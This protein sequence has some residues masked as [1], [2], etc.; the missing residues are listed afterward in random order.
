MDRTGRPTGFA[1]DLF[2]AVA[3]R[4]GLQPVYRV[5]PSYV[6]AQAALA[7]GEVEVVPNLGVVEGRAFL[8]TRPVETFEVSAFVRRANR[9][10]TSLVDV[11]GPIAVV[12]ANVGGR[13]VADLTH[14]EPVVFDNVRDALFRLLSGDVDVL[15]YPAPVVWALARR[16]RL[17]QEIVELEPPLLEVKRAIAV[18]SRSESLRD[19]LDESVRGFVGSAEYLVIYRRWHP[20]V[21]GFWTLRRVVL[22]GLG[23]FAVV[24]LGGA[25]ARVAAHRK[26]ERALRARERTFRALAEGLSDCVLIVSPDDHVIRYA[27]SRSVERFGR[28]P[29]AL[30]GL[31][32]RALLPADC[33]CTIGGPPQLVRISRAD[34]TSYDAE[35]VAGPELPEATPPGYLL[36]VADVTARR[37]ADERIR[38]QAQLIDVIGEAVIATDADGKVLFWSRF[39]ETLYGWTREEATGRPVVEL[40]TVGE[41]RDAARAI[42][43]SV[44]AGRTWSGE[45]EVSRRDGSTFPVFLTLT[46]IVDPDGAVVG[47]VG[48]GTDI[49]L[50]K[51]LEEQLRQSQKM[52]SIG[53][54]AGGIAHDFNNL[55]T[56]ISGNTELASED[57]PA[58]D[59]RIR[60]ELGEVR[61][62]ADRAAQLTRQLL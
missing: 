24:V 60:A 35:V 51:T 17:D 58:H 22:A 16:A 32:I 2:E 8:F 33:H 1:I 39:A 42:L 19:R 53:R 47:A 4:A 37:K 34:G 46:P 15:V 36:R 43:A 55:L 54:L 6:E 48:A 5:Y 61:R 26:F 12:E 29:E 31:P 20:G 28:P 11:T 10:V 23:V 49:G 9:G 25:G 3:A 7:S 59:E 27:N 14:R 41:D 21:G 62:A 38:F 13:L 57:L 44:F 52:E 56:V 50:R 30:E 45:F 40:V 18:H